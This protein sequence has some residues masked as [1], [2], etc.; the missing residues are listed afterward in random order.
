MNPLSKFQL[1]RTVN[2]PENAIL[3]KLRRLEKSMAPN[4]QK[5]GTCTY[6]TNSRIF[7]PQ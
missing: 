3:W 7:A 6:S 1:N 2:E 5:L 4:A